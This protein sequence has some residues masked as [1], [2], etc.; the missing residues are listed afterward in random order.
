MS[1]S[2]GQSA[3]ELL[4]IYMFVMLIFTIFVLSF[5][6]QRAIEIQNARIMLADSVGERFA[7]EL[8][9]AAQSGNGYSRKIIYPTRLDGITPYT[10]ILNNLSNTVDLQFT[11][12]AMNYSHSFPIINSFVIVN[13]NITVFLPNGT[14]YGYLLHSDNLSFSKGQMYIQNIDGAIMISTISYFV[15]TP[16]GMSLN[17]SPTEIKISGDSSNITAFLYDQF[18]N[19]VPDGTVVHFQTDLGAIQ[20]YVPTTNGIATTALISGFSTGGATV[21]A[22]IIISGGQISKYIKVS[23]VSIR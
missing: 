12:G 3:N 17:A 9:L 18:N 2:K 21:N 11:M 23:F 22:T 7:Y 6:Q 14:A 16:W 4:V 15:S 8:N 10:V 5:T 13:P 1:S 20:D 19:P